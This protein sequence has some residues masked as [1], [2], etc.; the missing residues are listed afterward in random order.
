MRGTGSIPR[1]VQTM[2]EQRSHGVSLSIRSRLR[3]RIAGKTDTAHDAE[4]GRR[5]EVGGVRRHSTAWTGAL[6]VDRGTIRK[7]PLT[8]HFDGQ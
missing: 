1:F 4:Q 3:R 7:Q 2:R 5:E 8:W 6:S